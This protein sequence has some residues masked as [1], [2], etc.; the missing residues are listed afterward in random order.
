MPERDALYAAMVLLNGIAS[1]SQYL[2]ETLDE[3]KK[4]FG[5][6]FYK[7]IDIKFPNQSEKNKVK[8]FIIDNI[9]ENINNHK[10]KSISNI[11][12][13]KSSTLGCKLK[14]LKILKR[15]ALPL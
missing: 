9:P 10:L 12:G 8:Q 6:S 7:R 14:F 11:D 2:F 13:I 15:L 4:D 3:I 5:P 1:K